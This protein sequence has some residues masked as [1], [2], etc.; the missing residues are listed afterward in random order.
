METQFNYI[1]DLAK[2]YNRFN[3]NSLEL[4]NAINA[5]PKETVQ[6]IYEEYGDT[7]TRFQPLNVLRSEI[8]R[9]LLNGS[10]V[11]EQL[12]EEV[13]NK[14]RDKDLTYFKHLPEPFLNELKEYTM[15]KR[16]VFANWQKP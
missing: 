3:E 10:Q 6:E 12:V 13:K 4:Y 14:I 9:I 5:L 7:D 11:N 1:T 8:A 15:G 2:Q 16:D